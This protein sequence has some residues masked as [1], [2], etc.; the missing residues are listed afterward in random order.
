VKQPIELTDAE[1]EVVAEAAY[2]AHELEVR[3][4]GGWFPWEDQT[5]SQEKW[6][7][8]VDA[9]VA[10]L[11]H[12]RA[13]DDPVGTVRLSEDGRVAIRT[14]QRYCDWTLVDLDG[15]YGDAAPRG[16]VADWPVIYSPEV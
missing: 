15:G 5:W 8:T 14:K 16:Y 6:R 7:K 9:A 12:S 3:G 1:R 13:G 10:A 2:I 4:D 11:N